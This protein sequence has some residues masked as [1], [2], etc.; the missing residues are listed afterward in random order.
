MS[1]LNCFLLYCNGSFYVAYTRN[2]IEYSNK[3]TKYISV[4]HFVLL[5]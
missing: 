1:V 3:F 2:V 5:R 4:L